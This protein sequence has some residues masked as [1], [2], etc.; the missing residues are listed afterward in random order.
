[1]MEVPIIQKPVYFKA[2]QWT[3]F[4]SFYDRDLLHERAKG[5]KYNGSLGK[6]VTASVVIHFGYCKIRK[7]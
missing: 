5:P 1:M 2:N 4:Y 3:G 6:Y 7:L